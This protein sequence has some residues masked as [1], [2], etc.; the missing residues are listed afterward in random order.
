MVRE[1]V[2]PPPPTTDRRPHVKADPYNGLHLLI[3]SWCPLPTAPHGAPSLSRAKKIPA[4][5]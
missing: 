4:R 1:G 2:Y 3:A 5:P